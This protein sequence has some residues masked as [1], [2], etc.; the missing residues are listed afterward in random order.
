MIILIWLIKTSSKITVEVESKLQI[1]SKGN[2]N[3]ASTIYIVLDG[4][5]QI[6]TIAMHSG[7]VCDSWE[8][9]DLVSFTVQIGFCFSRIEL[10]SK[11]NKGACE[12]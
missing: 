11:K 6:T 3:N 10:E 5:Y 4:S 1:A 12:V 8:D 2:F 9:T 7:K